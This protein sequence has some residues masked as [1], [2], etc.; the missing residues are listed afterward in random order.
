MA[1]DLA[2]IEY[3]EGKRLVIIDAGSSKT[4]AAILNREKGVVEESVFMSAINPMII[5]DS[6][7]VSR[8]KPLGESLS[9][10]DDIAFFGSGCLPGE[11]SARVEKAIRSIS[12]CSTVVVQSDIV[13]AALSL[14]GESEGI[15]CILGTGSNTALSK[16]GKI[17]TSIPSLGYILGDEGSG[18]AM[19]KRL[20]RSLFR[21]E[22]SKELQESFLEE[23]SQNLSD[24]LENVY[25]GNTPNRYLAQ[26]THFLAAHI[27]DNEI[28]HIVRNEF[29]NLFVN[30]ISRYADY[31]YLPVGFV[32]SVAKV[33]ET[34]LRHIA[35]EFQCNVA[36]VWA[37]PME[38]L[39][40]YFKNRN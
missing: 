10:G 34:Q 33:F 22:L 5:S 23:T 9:E 26:F 39:I 15:A 29:A 6:E 31:R 1:L 11:P 2:N 21:G 28:R 16:D 12:E 25:R 19:G 18:S 35:S 37:S 38:G 20:V 8:L 36:A 17:E 27:E 4:T 3:G 14:F 32:G 40:E 7:L 30:Q 24:V 13:A